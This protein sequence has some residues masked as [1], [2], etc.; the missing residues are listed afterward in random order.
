MRA[1]LKIFA[2]II[3]MLAVSCTTMQTGL[4]LPDPTVPTEACNIQLDTLTA[5]K[6]GTSIIR[7]KIPNPCDA[8]RLMPTAA[9]VG[10]VWDFYKAGALAEWTD[11]IAEKV[12]L[13]ITYAD[14][15][16][17]LTMEIKKFN[18][19][20]GG[21]YLVVSDMLVTFNEVTLISQK[22]QVILMAGLSKLRDDAKRLAM[23]TYVRT[24]G[25]EEG[26]SL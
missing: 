1:I 11:K 25:G 3:A 16:T 20:L 8:Y 26:G 13:G 15:N 17:L 24:D 21:T 7:A 6:T 19:K 18:G 2:T 5:D 22:D 9:K 12:Q 10:V 23:L 4:N 14:L